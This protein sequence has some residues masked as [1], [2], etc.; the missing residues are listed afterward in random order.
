MTH[1]TRTVER[2]LI[3]ADIG[4]EQ[5]G[6]VM[7]CRLVDREVLLQNGTPFQAA[8]VQQ[9]ALGPPLVVDEEMFKD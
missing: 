9:A 6:N 7:K 4:V 5:E 3:E 1:L 2:E 8:I